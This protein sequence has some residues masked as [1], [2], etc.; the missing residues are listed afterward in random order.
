MK[1][2]VVII[3]TAMAKEDWDLLL[4]CICARFRIDLVTAHDLHVPPIISL[5]ENGPSVMLRYKG[6]NYN[7]EE[8]GRASS[9][10]DVEDPGLKPRLFI[11][12]W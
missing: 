6:H 1:L 10:S 8:H 4:K 5:G 12:Y 11:M 7:I 9:Y 3:K 2:D